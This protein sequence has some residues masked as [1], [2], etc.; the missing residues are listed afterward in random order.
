MLHK[1]LNYAYLETSIV[2]TL[3]IIFEALL[4]VLQGK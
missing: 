1:N 2:A 4:R 3:I